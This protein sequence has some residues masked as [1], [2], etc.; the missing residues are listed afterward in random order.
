MELL[1]A[2]RIKKIV[3]GISLSDAHIESGGRL[4]FYS[5]N[6]EYSKYITNVLLQITNSGAKFSIKRDKRG[7]VGYRVLTKQHPYFSNIYKNVYNGRKE[8]NPYVVSRIDEE[9]LA[10][11]YMCD[12]YTEHAKNRKTNKIQ[13]IGWFCLEAFP[14]EELEL[15]GEHMKKN[16]GIDYSLPKKPCGFGYRLRVGGPDL[17]RL[18]SVIYPYMLDCFN[19][20]IPLF[21]KGKDYVL[22]LPNAEHYIHNYECIEDIVRHP[23]KV[24][25]T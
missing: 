15:L 3:Y 24:G 2:K 1:T 25:K 9:C 22:D 11:I 14:K 5:K 4:D 21:Y 8:L 17:Q 6:S 16:W 7:Y 23:T 10:H 13:N 19:Y 18:M 20:K 12:G